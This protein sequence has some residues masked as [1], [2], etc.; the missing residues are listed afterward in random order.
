MPWGAIASL[1]GSMLSARGQRDANR[2]NRLIA[3]ENREWQERMSNTAYQRS[4][5]DLEA[6]GLNRILALGGP[7]S[8]PAGNIATMQNEKAAY[9]NTGLLAAQ[10]NDIRASTQLKKA[11]ARA[12]TPAAEFGEGVG[13]AVDYSKTKLKEVEWKS[14]GDQVMRD[15][16]KIIRGISELSGSAAKSA[17]GALNRVSQQL[18]LRPEKAQ[19]HLIKTV[20]AMDVPWWWSDERKL[21]WGIQNI[22]WLKN[23]WKG[24]EN[25]HHDKC[26]RHQSNGST[27]GLQ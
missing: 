8:T 15:T 9:A 25:E 19:N 10:I 17:K 22:T 13:S 5:K 18:G 21:Q 4:A 20:E 24:T 11:Q 12:I 16:S 1:A 6:A 2:M 23:S 26:R 27:K 3:R 7:A 14:L